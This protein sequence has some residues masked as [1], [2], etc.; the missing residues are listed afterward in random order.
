MKR[1]ELKKV[2]PLVTTSRHTFRASPLARNTMSLSGMA[3]T[4]LLRVSLP[5]N[6]VW[7]MVE[8]LYTDRVGSWGGAS[9]YSS[10]RR[11]PRVCHSKCKGRLQDSYLPRDLCGTRQSSQERMCDHIL[12]FCG[13]ARR[14]RG[15]QVVVRRQSL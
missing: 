9:R 8:T 11:G 10:V 14:V 15:T 5:C 4:G 1:S 12:C 7:N 13:V 2:A 3:S 6:P